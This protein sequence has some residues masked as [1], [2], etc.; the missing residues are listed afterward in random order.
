MQDLGYMRSAPQGV[1]LPEDAVRWEVNRI[2]N[3]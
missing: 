1:I 3:E 2:H